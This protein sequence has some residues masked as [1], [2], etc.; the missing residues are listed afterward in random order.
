MQFHLNYNPKPSESKIDH[1]HK[2]MLIGSCFA[3]NIGGYLKSHKFKTFV[4]P[5]GILFNPNSIYCSLIN[6]IENK[7][8][9]DS[10]ILKRN[11]LFFSYL[12][13]S[14][15]Y[16]QDKN[17]LALKLN[18]I[19]KEAH[20]FIKE[21]DYLIIT[22]GTAFVYTHKQHKTVVANCHKQPSTDFEKKLL[23]VEEIVADYKN[24]IHQ[25]KLFNPKVKIIFTV[26][27]VKYLKDGVEENNISKATLLLAIH[28]LKKEFNLDYFPAFELVN[29]DLRDYRFYKEDLAH[30]NEQAV[31]YVWEKFS[32]VYFADETK[33]L[34]SEIHSI[35]SSEKHNLL[36]PE[37]EEAKKFV[38]SITI[39]KKELKSKF[40][41]LEI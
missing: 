10:Y 26:S 21:T 36:F 4:N 14:S 25:L 33:N 12:H 39:K 30:P 29:D 32:D 8:I 2:I 40:P 34:N 3:E 13:H 7:T 24:L 16:H 18:T 27:P 19:Q 11:E 17:E 22:F 28:Q 9:D 1:Q 20:Y 23:T 5:N 37:S 6:C 38:A 31:N 15:T 41:F 35:I